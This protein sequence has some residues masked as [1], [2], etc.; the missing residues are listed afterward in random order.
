M[1]RFGRILLAAAA[2]MS[3]WTGC[4]ARPPTYSAQGYGAPQ[5]VN[6]YGAGPVASPGLAPT[7][8]SNPQFQ[9]APGPVATPVI[10]PQTSSTVIVTPTVT[11]SS[12]YS[13]V[14]PVWGTSMVQTPGTFY[15]PPQRY[16][17]LSPTY[18]GRP[19]RYYRLSRG[20]Y[21]PYYW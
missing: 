3:G 7:P 10:N 19:G 15:T 13:P 5:Y 17:D 8:I 9:S 18:D 12:Y 16:V 6:S 2:L 21:G 11:A 4:V 14:A 1:R 20:G